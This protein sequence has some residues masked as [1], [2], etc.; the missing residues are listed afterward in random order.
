[1]GKIPISYK[2]YDNGYKIPMGICLTIGGSAPLSGLFSE[3][4]GVI[5]L[6]IICLILFFVFKYLNYACAQEEAEENFNANIEFL[7]K[8]V[9]IVLNNN[10]LDNEE[11][12]TKIIKLS[13]EGNVYATLFLNELSKKIEGDE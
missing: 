3:E 7:K 9:D 6:G 4:I 11:K 13:N 2:A 1:M 8:E 10:E 5:V 12:I